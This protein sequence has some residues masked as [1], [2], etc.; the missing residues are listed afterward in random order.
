MTAAVT[1]LI[2]CDLTNT[3]VW[4]DITSGFRSY[5]IRRGRSREVD[6]ITTGTLTVTLDNATGD[7]TPGNT[8]G[9]YYPNIKAGR[10]IRVS[11]TVTT[12]QVYLFTGEIDSW[13]VAWSDDD[14][15]EL[16]CVVTASDAFERLA[17]RNCRSLYAETVLDNTA[18]PCVAYY[19]LTEPAGSVSFANGQPAVPQPMAQLVAS[20]YGAGTFVAGDKA[21]FMAG[22]A[23]QS[24]AC[25]FTH[26]GVGN[27][28][29]MST[30]VLSGGPVKN[31][32]EP[33][34]SGPWTWGCWFNIPI[35]PTDQAMLLYARAALFTDP[36]AVSRASSAK[37][38]M[39]SAGKINFTLQN[40]FGQI[41]TV[42]SAANYAGGNV[43]HYVTASL[44]ADNKTM[45]LF[46]D[47][48]SATTVMPTAINASAGMVAFSWFVAGGQLSPWGESAG[49]LNGSM[50]SVELYS[51]ADTALGNGIRWLFGR[52]GF[53]ISNGTADR[54]VNLAQ[55]FGF[56]LFSAPFVVAETG[57]TTQVAKYD[58][59][60]SSFL[61]ALQTYT[62]T[63]QGVLYI[64]GFGSLIFKSRASRV[65]QAPLF[66]LDNGNDEIRTGLGFGIDKQLLTNEFAA[67][68]AGGAVQRVRDTLSGSIDDYG[69]YSNAPNDE[70]AQVVLLTTDNEVNDYAA[71]KVAQYGQPKPRSPSMSVDMLTN[72]AIWPTVVKADIG[73]RFAAI[74]MPAQAPAVNLDLIIESVSWEY[75]V[76][77]AQGLVLETSPADVTT[78]LTA[79]D[80]VYGLADS[81]SAFY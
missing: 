17:R 66:V 74:N 45:T 3:G 53:Y 10:P 9:A 64:D 2:E 12:G 1:V 4:V 14:Q 38:Y 70:S 59:A 49:G 31:G 42:Q 36:F 50:A 24:T 16:L 57:V 68:R 56:G 21:G 47:S 54:V 46:V 32:A 15:R 55:N 25:T 71:F 11:V 34:S 43:W 62:A 27:V 44:A 19:P 5:S 79:D 77:G 52:D 76:G 58:I 67:V 20:K 18:F 78:Y 40:R 7:F 60:G 51:A 75:V 48:S 29:G 63:E 41:G 33:P 65:N 69:V 37:L 72:P 28:E 22:G 23:P 35:A 30:V 8:A 13:G 39:D 61:A 6:E 73:V 81:N 80:P 26:S